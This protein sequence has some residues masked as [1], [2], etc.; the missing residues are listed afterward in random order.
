MHYDTTHRQ[1]YD[2]KLVDHT[3]EEPLI[4]RVICKV[5]CVFLTIWRVSIPKIPTLFKGQL[6]F[7][8]ID[9]FGEN[10]NF[11]NDEPYDL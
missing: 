2:P 5:V 11:K 9:Q 1:Y 3:D 6:C 4:E 8:F 7:E 10:W